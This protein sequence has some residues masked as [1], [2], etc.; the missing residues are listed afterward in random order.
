MNSYTDKQIG[1]C[2]RRVKLREVDDIGENNLMGT[3]FSYK[4]NV[5][6]INRMVTIINNMVL[7]I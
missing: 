2:Q 1:G 5:M 3:N 4:I 7:H 6:E